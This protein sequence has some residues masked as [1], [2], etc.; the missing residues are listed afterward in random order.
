MY[1]RDERSSQQSEHHER[2]DNHDHNR[3]LGALK[4]EESVC[5]FGRACRVCGDVLVQAYHDAADENNDEHKLAARCHGVV[6]L[7][8][9]W[10]A[11]QKHYE[12]CY[13]NDEGCEQADKF[14]AV[15]DHE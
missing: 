6:K 11:D 2:H 4:P 15:V 3:L 14:E 7:S 8:L 13:C 12:K 1:F 10:P 9:K 5:E